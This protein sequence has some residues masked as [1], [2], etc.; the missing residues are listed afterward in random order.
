MVMTA[1][2]W[3]KGVN[4]WS[5]ARCHAASCSPRT[6]SGRVQFFG[7]MTK[8]SASN[9]SYTLWRGANTRIWKGEAGIP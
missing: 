5:F 7:V 9:S 1:V 8:N 6:L 4:L 2:S 3:R